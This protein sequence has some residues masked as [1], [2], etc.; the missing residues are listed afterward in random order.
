MSSRSRLGVAISKRIRAWLTPDILTAEDSLCRQLAIPND[1]VLIAAVNGALNLLCEPENWE[2]FG[3]MTPAAAA[4]HMNEVYAAYIDSECGG[5]VGGVPTPFWDEASD[6]DDQEPDATQ[7]WYGEV[8]DPNAAAEDLTFVENAA[9]WG[10]TGFLAFSGVPGAALLF[11]TIAP[12]FVL[13]MRGGDFGEVIR[14]LVDG[15]DAAKVDTTGLAGE[16]IEIPIAGNPE[17]SL[18]EI[19]LILLG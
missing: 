14:I 8:A 17:I 2:Q 12:S 6:V 3:T 9:I 7:S 19:M 10:F 5:G 16:L 1:P 11:H 13:A 4:E 18:H 15:E